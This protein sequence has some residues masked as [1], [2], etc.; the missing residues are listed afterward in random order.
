[1]GTVTSGFHN[2]QIGDTVGV[3]GPLGNGWPIEQM[4]GKNIVVIGGGFAFSTKIKTRIPLIMITKAGKRKSR[5]S[6]LCQKAF[7]Y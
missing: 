3:R 7:G 5:D 4:K 6:V 1:M 2:S